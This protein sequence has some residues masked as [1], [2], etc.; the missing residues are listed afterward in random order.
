MGT[1]AVSS[2]LANNRDHFGSPAGVVVF[3]V[4]G[5]RASESSTILSER[6]RAYAV[7]LV[8][9]SLLT[10]GLARCLDNTNF[11]V[12]AMSTAAD[13]VVIPDVAQH[14]GLVLVIDGC[15]IQGALHDVRSFRA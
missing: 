12:V 7:I 5:P 13:Q 11:Q 6:S 8:G 4:P 1:C 9:S 14:G 3:S 10:H 15:D 2:V